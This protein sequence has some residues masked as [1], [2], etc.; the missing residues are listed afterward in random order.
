MLF[1]ANK[2]MPKIY[3]LCLLTEFTLSIYF[4]KLNIYLC[5]GNLIDNLF[6]YQ[7]TLYTNDFQYEKKMMD[8][9]QFDSI[10][11]NKPKLHCSQMLSSQISNEILKNFLF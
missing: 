5:C 2:R 9:I 1:P 3:A 6:L 10:N 4:I 8:S 11:S 7:I